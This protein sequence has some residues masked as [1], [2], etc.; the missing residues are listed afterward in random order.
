MPF[1]CA[2]TTGRLRPRRH[3]RSV[4]R[5][6]RQLDEARLAGSVVD[7]LRGFLEVLRLRPED[8]GD[9]LLRV[10]VVEG[11][12][13][14]LHLHHDPMPRAEDV[15]RVGQGEAVGERLVGDEGP[16][17]FQA[18]PV[19]AA[20]DVGRDHELV[21]AH[22]RLGRHLVGVDVD[23]LHDPVGVR[24]AGGGDEVGDR[25]AADLQ[26][27]GQ[28]VGH[29]GHHVRAAGSL[30]LVVDEP[31][32]P[33]PAVV[34]ADRLDRTRA[35]GHGLGG[36]GHV[37]LEGSVVRLRSGEAQLE[38]GAEVERR[39]SDR[40]AARAAGRPRGQAP[41]GV[42]PGLVG[43]DRS[44]VGRGRAVPEVLVEERAQ[45]LLA[46]VEGGVASESQRAE[47]AA[48]PDLLAVIPRAHDQEHLVVGRV[49]GL[50]RPV[51]G[52]CSV[53]VL[54]VPEAVDQHHRHAQR[55][56][57]QQPVDGLVTPEA[58]VARVLEELP[59]EAHLLQAAATSELPADPAS[60]NVS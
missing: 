52:R 30:T 32:G 4:R 22:R 58:V 56:R 8:A 17:R 55:L 19:A 53:D 2:L 7:P 31:L 33:G 44:Q 3:T 34:V 38:P 5:D 46:E 23:E 9:V 47:R 29:E 49:L 24:P 50:E 37:L 15:V 54:L 10:A 25:L 16:G 59:P 14:R 41:P 43:G 42:G 13:A 36:R 45:D 57:R 26:G 12:P 35:E 40:A 51:D 28:H 27:L 20:E 39:R 11:E 1:A 48:V 60:R 6:P 21:A 18:L